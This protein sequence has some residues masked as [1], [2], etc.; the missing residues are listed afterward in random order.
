MSDR[1]LKAPDGVISRRHFLYIAGGTV[2]VTAGASVLAACGASGTP[3]PTAAPTAAATAAASAAAECPVRTPSTAAI[4]GPLNMFTWAGYEGMGVPEMEQ[5]YKDNKIEL[6][7]KAISNE[8][9]IAFFKS[10]AGQEWDAGSENQGNCNYGYE[11]GVM[12]AVSV[13]EVPALGK[14]YPFF[15]ESPLFKICDGVYN[16]VPWTTGPLAINTRPEKVPADALESYEGLFDAKWKGR[17]ATFDD[18]LNMIS[19]GAVA[20]GKDPGKLTR[21]ELNGPVRDWLKRLMPQLKVAAASIGD[22]VNLLVSGDIDINLVGLTWNVKQAKDQGVTIDLRTPKE[23][24]YG[25]IDCVR[26]L[27]WAKNRQNAIAY[28]NAV[29]EGETAVALQNSLAQLG[30]VD[31]VNQAVSKDTRD[32]FPEDLATYF[33]ETLKWNV[34]YYDPNGPYAPFEEWQKTWADVKAGV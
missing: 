18:A 5:W 10:P 15:K 17:I 27:P 3:A 31:S 26:I 28:A 13:E 11:N 30:T 34:S 6:N 4:G 21:D 19:I 20:T 16:S 24:A 7:V 23:G 12:D 33:G 32:L 8:D 25:F 1:P 29:M 9:P 14:M 22:Q 2:A